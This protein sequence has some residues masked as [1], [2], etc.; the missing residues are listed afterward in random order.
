[1]PAHEQQHVADNRMPRNRA[2]MRNEAEMR[3]FDSDNWFKIT[4]RRAIV[5]TPILNR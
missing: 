1:M 5:A 3:G 2:R 4:G